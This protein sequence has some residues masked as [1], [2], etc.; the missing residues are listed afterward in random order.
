V[1]AGGSTDDGHALA[2]QVVDRGG[3]CGVQVAGADDLGATGGEGEQQRDGLRLQV[4]AGPD[5]HAVE[6][7]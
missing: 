4:D 3:L 1:V 2:A 7:P 6:R 5:R